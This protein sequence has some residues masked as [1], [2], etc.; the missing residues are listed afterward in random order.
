[1]DVVSLGEEDLA[2][3][4]WFNPDRDICFKWDSWTISGAAHWNIA[5]C[6]FIDCGSAL[7]VWGLSRNLRVDGE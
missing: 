6:A 7:S 2:G 5:G 3:N 1:V 4:R